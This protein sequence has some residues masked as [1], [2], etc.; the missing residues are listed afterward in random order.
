MHGLK[1]S[2][3]YN[4]FTKGQENSPPAHS[5]AFYHC[6]MSICRK[7]SRVH[8]KSH[9]SVSNRT[10]SD[11]EFRCA[12]GICIPLTWQCDSQR[13]CSDGS[14]EDLRICPVKNCTQTQY[15]CSPG[16]C[17]VKAWT[18]DGFADCLNGKDEDGCEAKVCT[19]DEFTCRSTPGECVPLTWMCDDNPD[20]SDGS[21][22]KSCSK[23]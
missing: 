3:M 15:E 4:Y 2:K 18:C 7:R 19:P 10:C 8:R 6:V 17:I 13:D 22:E 14:D 1:V 23:K 16:Y 11:T 9:L 20:C 5:D 12:N 21:D